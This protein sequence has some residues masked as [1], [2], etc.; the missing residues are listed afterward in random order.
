M[1]L[2]NELG[3]LIGRNPPDRASQADVDDPRPEHGTMVPLYTR[4]MRAFQGDPISYQT[5]TSTGSANPVSLFT[6]VAGARSAVIYVAG[7]DIIY[8]VDGANPVAVGDQV[9]QQGSTVT[10]TGKP[11]MMGFIFAG[12]IGAATLYITYYD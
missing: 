11:T 7:G 5:I 12:R 3:E 8:R 1:R 9:I 4:M 6:N 10:L 2:S